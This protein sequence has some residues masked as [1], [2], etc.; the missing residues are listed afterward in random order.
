MKNIHA[1]GTCNNPSIKEQ[2]IDFVSA[3][4]WQK[5]ARQVLSVKF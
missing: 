2:Y 1:M 5:C 3:D 4:V